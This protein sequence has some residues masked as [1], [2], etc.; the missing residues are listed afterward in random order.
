MASAR[1]HIALTPSTWPHESLRVARESRGS[2]ATASC[3][4]GSLPAL[5]VQSLS[6]E[7]SVFMVTRQRLRC[8]RGS[9][10]QARGRGPS[11][12]TGGFYLGYDGQ[13]TSKIAWNA[14]KEFVEKALS[15]LSTFN[16]D[17]DYGP[18]HVNVTGSNT[19]CNY[20]EKYYMNSTEEYDY[21]NAQNVTIDIRGKYGNVYNLTLLNSLWRV[22]SYTNPGY[23]YK[24]KVNLTLE[25]SKGT[26][27]NAYCSERGWCDFAT[28]TCMCNKLDT[29]RLQYD[30]KSSNG[31]GEPGNRRRLW[32][33]GYRS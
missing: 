25:A 13:F 17:S 2:V 29:G 21:L 4:T 18:L 15:A 11:N 1:F 3:R 10:H 20:D 14:T 7:G 22:D 5:K 33:S 27:E 30:Y 31:Y 23:A 6:L 9:C 24:E 19:V 8:P 28:G 32:L 12:C 26:K 16:E